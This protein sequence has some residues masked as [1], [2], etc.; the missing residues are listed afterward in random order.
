MSPQ[1]IIAEQDELKAH[2]VNFRLWPR[3]WMSVDS[4]HDYTW[5]L[6]ELSVSD[7]GLIPEESGLYSLV[8]RPGIFGHPACSYLMYVG[9][10]KSLRRRF[11]EYRR[12]MSNRKGRKKIVR[13]LNK[14]CDHIWFCF[15]IV[16]EPDISQVEDALL[17]AFMPPF[18]DQFPATVSRVIGAWS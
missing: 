4:V 17:E 15:T 7:T 1:D 13:L 8:V 9:K 18:N 16:P 2:E 11:R 14:Y 6:I 12:E 5:K 10:T 3:Q